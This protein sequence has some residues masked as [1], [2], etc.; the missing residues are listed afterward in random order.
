MTAST[1]EPSN[2]V[3]LWLEIKRVL[4]EGPPTVERTSRVIVKLIHLQR[5]LEEI[6]E[7]GDIDQSDHA[8]LLGGTVEKLIDD[9]MEA[10]EIA[11]RWGYTKDED[12]AKEKQELA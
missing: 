3:S 2:P 5:V 10:K 8:K 12:F 9:C 7:T 1:I 11:L 4:S 6:A